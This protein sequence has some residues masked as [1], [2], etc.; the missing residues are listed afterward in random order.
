MGTFSE[1]GG[2]MNYFLNNYKAS[3][4]ILSPFVHRPWA[5]TVLPVVGLNSS[6]SYKKV[7]HLESDSNRPNN[8]RL[9]ED[10]TVQVGYG[11]Y[12]IS[13]TELRCYAA[14]NKGLCEGHRYGKYFD[15]VSVV[16]LPP[17]PSKYSP[18]AS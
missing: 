8:I 3:S 14:Y 15:G 5:D 4:G 6:H 13:F 7:L 17:P 16:K 10:S 2:P 12:G 18:L 11:I 1:I 9:P